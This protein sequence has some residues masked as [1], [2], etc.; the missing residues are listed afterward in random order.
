[1]EVFVTGAAGYLGGSVAVRLMEAGH[2]VRGLVRDNAKADALRVMGIEPVYGS[3]DDVMVLRS[4]AKRVDAVVNAAD[5]DHRSAVEVLID[6]M[7]GTEKPLL[8]TSGISIIGD[9]ALGDAS[10]AVFYEDTPIRPHLEK[11]A[12]REID[13]LVLD[14]A[15]RGV[16]SVVLCNSLVYGAG[17]GLTKD[18]LQLPVLVADAKENGVARHIGA[19]QNIWSTVHISDVSDLYLRALEHARPGTFM[20]VENGEVQFRDIASAIASALGVAGPA[21]WPPAD[22]IRVLGRARAVFSLGSNARVRGRLARDELG[23]TPEHRD[24]LDWIRKELEN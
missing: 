11:H 2:G 12:R 6:A 20:Y 3:L 4:Q 24:V 21:T 13:E 7:A 23:W 10:D 16:R 1:M 22:A 9:E 15:G 8:H 19:G 18:S 14:A 17:L 5:S